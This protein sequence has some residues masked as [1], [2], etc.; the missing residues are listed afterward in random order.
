[1]HCF[2]KKRCLFRD[3]SF[4]AFFFNDEETVIFFLLLLISNSTW[5]SCLKYE[6]RQEKSVFRA[7]IIFQT[8]FQDAFCNF[9]GVFHIPDNVFTK[10]L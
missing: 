1:M 8:I 10:M 7:S 6:R 5:K 2:K 4:F 9:P 3:L